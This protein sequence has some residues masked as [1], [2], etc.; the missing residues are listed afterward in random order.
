M[1]QPTPSRATD[2][3]AMAAELQPLLERNAALTAEHCSTSKAAS[4]RSYD[5]R[6]KLGTQGHGVSQLIFGTFMGIDENQIR[7]LRKEVITQI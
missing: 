5:R 6:L 3:V 7:R 2:P 4:P 1:T